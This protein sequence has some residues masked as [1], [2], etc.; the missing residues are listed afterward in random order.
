MHQ[1]AYRA[2]RDALCMQRCKGV[3][4]Q[5]ALGCCPRCHPPVCGALSQD[6]SSLGTAA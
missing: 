5:L 4:W 3:V 6:M 1:P 2:L